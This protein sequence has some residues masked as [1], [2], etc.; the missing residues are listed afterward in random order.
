MKGY[1]TSL[2]SLIVSAELKNQKPEPGE[3]SK[4]HQ[5]FVEFLQSKSVQTNILESFGYL[6]LLK[7]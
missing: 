6:D 4:I 5:I 1:E 7:F 3:H 2:S